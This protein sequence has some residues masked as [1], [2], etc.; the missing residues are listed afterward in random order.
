MSREPRKAEMVA[1]ASLAYWKAWDRFVDLPWSKDGSWR[2][3]K[4]LDK[5]EAT[6][7][8][9]MDSYESEARGAQCR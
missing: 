8:S 7:R 2:A 9:A 1:D 4:E 6:L 5:T 3:V